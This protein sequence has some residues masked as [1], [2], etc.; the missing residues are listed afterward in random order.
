MAKK[1]K[2]ASQGAG[3]DAATAKHEQPLQAVLLADSFVNSFRPLSLDR[4]KVLCPLNNVTLIDYAIAFL[5]G[6]GVEELFV[7]CVSDQVEEHVEQHAWTASTMSV[8]VVKDNFVT[9]AGD[10]LR[11]LDKRNLVQSDPFILMFGDVVTNVDIGEALATHKERHKK[12]SSAIMTLLMKSVG[13]THISEDGTASYASIRAN[14]EDLV[15]GLDPSH[16]NR[17]MVYDDHNAERSVSVPCSFFASHPQID[18]RSDLLDCGIDICSPDVLAR[19]SDEFDYRDIRREFVA[20]SVAEEEEG[21]QNKIYAHILKPNEYAARVHDFQTYA[22]VSKDLLRRWCYPIVPDNL[23]S[24]YEKQYRYT[25][26]RHYLYRESKNRKSRVGRSS[27]VQGPGLIGS[28]CSVGENCRIQG[29]VLGHGCFVESKATIKDSHIWD[30]VHVAEGATV[31][32]S[33]LADGCVIKAGAVVSRGCVIGAGCIVGE[34]VVLPE[35]TR[36]TLAKETED[37]DFDD[38]WDDDNEEDDTNDT[39]DKAP[40]SSEDPV[41]VSDKDVV[42]LDGKG[43]VW[44]PPEDEAEDDDDEPGVLSPKDLMKS[45][46]IGFTPSALYVER[47]KQQKEHDDGFS[48]DDI[49]NG[50]DDDFVEYSDGGVT[51]G[52][53]GDSTDVSQEEIIIGRTKGVDVIKELKAICLEFEATNPIENLG[54]ELNSFKFSQ[55]ATYSDCTMAATLAILEMMNIAKGTKDGKLVADF[56]GFLGNWAPLL[57]KMSIGLD[58]EKAIIVALETSATGDGEM[59]QVLSTGTTYR[60]LLQTLFDEEIVSEEAF[61]SWAAERRGESDDSP[62]VKLFRSKTIQDFLEWLEEDSEDGSGEDDSEED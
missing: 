26:Q 38:D 62:R 3:D 44:Q 52:I 56:K 54:I 15:V 8:T 58:E 53:P 23:P 24:G 27:T 41:F 47:E 43:R 37:D 2:K 13:A 61:L 34:K 35:F 32:N 29:S 28:D 16:A 17:I 45:Q 1:Q 18:M 11:E 6:A 20:N 21:L 33:I 14:T 50:M 5:A 46:S 36:L 31:V 30:N 9:N 55:N 12:D 42:G 19:F 60:F 40:K 49:M 39:N 51:F 48:D 57:Q 4:P 22:N 7:V 25:L 10:A 59:G